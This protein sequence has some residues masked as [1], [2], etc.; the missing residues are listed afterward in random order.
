MSLSLSL[1]CYGLSSLSSDHSS[2]AALPSVGVTEYNIETSIMRRLRP[3]RVVEPWKKKIYILFKESK[4]FVACTGQ[5]LLHYVN[6]W[7][8]DCICIKYLLRTGCC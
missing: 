5:A 1:Q 6:R 8:S 2:R 4:S 7:P 3:I